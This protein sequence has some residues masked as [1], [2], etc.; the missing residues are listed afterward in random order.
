MKGAAPLVAA[1]VA[2]ASLLAFASPANATYSGVNGR[3]GFQRVFF[4]SDG[5]AARIPIFTVRPNGSHLRQV[6][7][8]ALGVETARVRWSPNGRWLAYMH[9][10]LDL[11]RGHIVVVRP[12]RDPPH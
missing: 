3:I 8:P 7:H 5:S 2:N 1:L 11:R 12:Q 4:G 9:T 6:T 10:K